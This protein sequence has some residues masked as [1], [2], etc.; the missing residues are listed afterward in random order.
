MI[1]P[2]DGFFFFFFWK[3]HYIQ[4]KCTF[5]DLSLTCYYVLTDNSRFIHWENRLQLHINLNWVL[6]TRWHSMFIQ[7]FC[8]TDQQLHALIRL[9]ISPPSFDTGAWMKYLGPNS[10]NPIKILAELRFEPGSPDWEADALTTTPQAFA[11]KT[12]GGNMQPAGHIQPT[13]DNFLARNQTFWL[14]S[15]P[16]DAY[17]YVIW[18]AD[19]NSCTPLF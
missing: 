12:G 15:G 7:N 6:L 10:T 16:R 17:K 8:V 18:P 4:W 2:F 11:S 19:E 5:N 13:K 3:Q 9:G 1:S 14:R